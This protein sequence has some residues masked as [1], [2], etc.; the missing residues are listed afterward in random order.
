MVG[1][2]TNMKKIVTALL[3]AASF[4]T[5]ETAANAAVLTF[6]EPEF[7]TDNIISISNYQDFTFNNFGV[8]NALNAAKNGHRPNDSGYYTYPNDAYNKYGERSSFS[9]AETFNLNDA[10]I[11]GWA[12]NSFDL[13]IR[14]TTTEGIIEKLLYLNLNERQHITF[15]Y[16][17]VSLVEF[18][19]FNHETGEEEGDNWFTIDNIRY[20]ESPVPEPSSILLGFMGLSSLF[21]LRRKQELI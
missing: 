1:R 5:F 12:W 17:G 4:L 7:M 3:M 20:N 8:L 13:L 10:Y 21:G 2:Q 19:P 16:L 6:D 15:N 18:I 14:T 11:A 9:R